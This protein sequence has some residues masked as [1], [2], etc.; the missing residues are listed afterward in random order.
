M[1]DDYGRLI[2]GQGKAIDALREQVQNQDRELA[3]V[4]EA[5]RIYHAQIDSMARDIAI[6][7]DSVTTAQG[8]LQFGRWLAGIAA[9][10]S[11][12]AIALWVWLKTGSPP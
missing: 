5:Q 7:K 10:L 6:I 11:G 1:M 4:K 9:T 8:G 2:E 3:A 12:A